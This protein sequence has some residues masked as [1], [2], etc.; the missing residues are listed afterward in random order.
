MSQDLTE[1]K[2]ANCRG[3]DLEQGM[4]RLIFLIILHT[5]IYIYIGS[6]ILLQHKEE[7]RPTLNSKNL[8]KYL[9]QFSRD[10]LNRLVQ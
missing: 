9:Q 3:E 6:N 1:W 2:K 5:Y 8:A 10:A 7:L 4:I